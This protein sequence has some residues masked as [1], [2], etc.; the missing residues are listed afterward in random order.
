[1]M[2]IK[3]TR[4]QEQ[5]LRAI[6]GLSEKDPAAPVT[7]SAVHH[8]FADMDVS[9]LVPH[10]GVLLESGLIRNARPTK[11][12]ISNMYLITPEGSECYRRNIRKNS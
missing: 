12:K 11:E 2:E 5:V 6:A 4:D 7:I 1:M 3:L 8:S 10:L 9:E